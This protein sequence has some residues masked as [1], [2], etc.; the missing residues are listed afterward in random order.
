MK[1]HIT[2]SLALALAATLATAEAKPRK[3]NSYIISD[4]GNNYFVNT[5]SDG[6][7]V[8]FTD[9]GSIYVEPIGNNG[10]FGYQIINTGKGP[11]PSAIIPAIIPPLVDE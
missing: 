1:K 5:H 3:D 11:V 9:K 4:G 2:L 6:S 8:T 7:S 10:D